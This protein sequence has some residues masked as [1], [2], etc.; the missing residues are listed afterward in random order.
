MSTI[1]KTLGAA[2]GA[3]AALFCNLGGPASAQTPTP[4]PS[5]EGGATQ[6]LPSIVV[7][8]P[9]QVAGRPKQRPKP[10]AVAL[11]AV[12][13]PQT[14]APLSPIA[15]LEEKM[16]NFD[17]SRSNLYTTAGTTSD[18]ISHDAIQN[19][20]QG[21]NQSVEK[22]L[23][24]AP[25]VSQDSAVAGALHVRNDHA[26]VQFRINGVM[27][28]DGVTGFGSIFDTSFIG[29]IA[30]VTGALPAEFG[31]RTVGLVDVTTR[32]D[33]FNNSGTVSMY[34]GSHGTINP[35][36]EYGGTFGGNCAAAPT[37]TATSTYVK[38]P[39][40]HADCFPGVQYYFTGSY[41]QTTVGLENSTP[42]SNAIHDFSQQERGF[43]YMSA[44][45]NPTT[46]V[47]LIAGTSNNNFQIPNTPGQPIGQNGFVTNAFG[48]T[49]FDSARLN[50]NQ[51][52]TTHFG[53]LSVQTS[54]DGF[55]GQLSY[56]TRYNNLHFLPDPV[57][58]L[59][60]NG[61]SSTVT[62]TSYTNGIQGDASYQVSSAHTL[63]TG[64]TVSG[65]QIFA[66]NTSLVEPCMIC[67]GTDNGA[68]ESITDNVS[69]LGVLMG[70]Y[71]QDEWKL[72]NQVTINAGLRF[73]QMYEFT[74][75]NQL[76]PRLSVTYKPFE[77]TTFHAGYARYFTPPVLVEA[78]P[79]NIALFNNTTGAASAGAA[80]DPILP[81]R[82]HYFD[83]G[84]D[85]RIPLGCTSSS[86]KDCSSLELGVDAYY[87]IAT[88][89]IDNG[90]FGQALVLSAFNYAKGWNEGIEFHAKYNSGN[91][92]AYANVAVAQQRAT[93][94][95]SNQY[96]FDNTVPL[97][98]L[99]GLTRLQYVQT[100]F[101]YTDHNQF[102]TASAGASYTFCGRPA[103]VAEAFGDALS[104]CGTTLS[105][106]AIYGSGL[107]NG[108]ANIGTVP[109]YTQVNVGIKREFLLPNDPKPMTVRFDVV[110]LFDEIYAIREG[111]GIGVFAPQF[112]PRRGFFLGISKKI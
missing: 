40:A 101:I 105:A 37:T 92:Q 26:N 77:N 12:S 59:L 22:V 58:D 110:N 86:P 66:G 36:F 44:F 104:W 102:V 42:A 2:C 84:V 89:L 9:K 3:A 108:D 14:P 109:D 47:S 67:D 87:K 41:L 5:A 100:H 62:R 15:Q 20:P 31:L 50:E 45:I 107:R 56:F 1:S 57:G 85:Q 4:P 27:L 93:D 53:V 25:G 91:F 29:S 70:V 43:A 95:V 16:T 97:P 32:N 88:D 48:V 65:E 30:L 33:I 112:G 98:D 64:F 79:A 90:T 63:R 81:E 106:D 17:Q 39:P 21:T 38:A 11:R 10:H 19:L 71:V 69:K 49:S 8:A 74:D 34:G 46:R 51:W 80:N 75:A 18:T 94:P 68:P 61:I 23:L 82:S 13:P 52:E 7:E 111:G 83:A 60:L 103:T 72:T 78:A 28:P 35:S 76:S 96:L 99:G 73:D 55:D 24:Q 6:Q 54:V